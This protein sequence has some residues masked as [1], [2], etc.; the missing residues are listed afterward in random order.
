MS[1]DNILLR[2][3]GSVRETKLYSLGIEIEESE[4]DVKIVGW[5]QTTYSYNSA[6]YPIPNLLTLFY[7]NYALQ[8]E[9]HRRGTYSMINPTKQANGRIDVCS[10]AM[11]TFLCS[12][13]DE[14]VKSRDMIKKGMF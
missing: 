7:L 9:Q 3:K 14:A 4:Y 12:D 2:K 5:S 13:C 11:I 1:L 8:P 10:A 6:G